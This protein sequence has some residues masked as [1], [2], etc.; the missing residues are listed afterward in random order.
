MPE[1]DHGPVVERTAELGPYTVDLVMFRQDMDMTETYAS[2]PGGRCQCPHWGTLLGGR[3]VVHYE[4]HD[5]V[6]EAGDQ[7]YMSPG[8]VPEIAA[9]T[10][11]VMFSPTDQVAATNAAIQAAMQ[12]G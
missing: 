4:D 9:G 6:I 7:Y 3:V 2:L 10:E 12:A 11:F 8:H 1:T 5:E